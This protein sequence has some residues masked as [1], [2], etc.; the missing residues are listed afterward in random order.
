MRL[1]I[2][3]CALVAATG[4]AWAADSSS[5]QVSPAN[6][7]AL[8]ATALPYS[9]AGFYIRSSGDLSPGSAGGAASTSDAAFSAASTGSTGS[10]GG[11]GS[12]QIGAN[13]QNGNNVFGFESDMQWSSQWAAPLSACGLGCSLNDRV[14]VPWMATVRA[15]AGKAF[16]RVYVYGT[17]GFAT[18]GIADSLNPAASSDAPNFVDLSAGNL[19]WAIG[20][21]MEF[22]IDQNV[23]ATLE[24]LHTTPA[25]GAQESLFDAATP[26]SVKNDIVRGGLDY[27]LPIGP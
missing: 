10:V 24:Y 12:G 21:G 27:R 22:A 5:A 18:S 4:L 26:G 14:K 1:L 13:W 6:D 2:A 7:A 19:D 17:G 11:I 23:S 8:S 25:T 16:D 9:W 15:R 20:G 3:S